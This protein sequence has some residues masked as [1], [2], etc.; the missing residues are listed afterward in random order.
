MRGA[1][2]AMTGASARA[3]ATQS[4]VARSSIVNSLPPCT[5]GYFYL[6]R[7]LRSIAGHRP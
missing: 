2:A 6:R 3:L 7:Q 5:G 4:I 1:A